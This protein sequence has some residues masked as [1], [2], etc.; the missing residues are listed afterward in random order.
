[1]KSFQ[2]GFYSAAGAL[3]FVLVARFALR[4]IFPEQVGEG[5]TA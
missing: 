5:E 1:M 3:A 4:V 2:S